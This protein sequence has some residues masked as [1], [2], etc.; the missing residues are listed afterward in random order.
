MQRKLDLQARKQELE[1]YFKSADAIGKLPYH[2]DAYHLWQEYTEHGNYPYAG[3]YYDQPATW[4]DDMTYVAA[5]VEY[6]DIPYDI[7]KANEELRELAQAK[8]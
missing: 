2:T 3:G 1:A 7:E 5:Q 4:R 8:V 6:A